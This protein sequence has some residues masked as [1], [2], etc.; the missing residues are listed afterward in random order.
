MK[1]LISKE[2]R[3]HLKKRAVLEF[4]GL[5]VLVAISYNQR[6]LIATAMTDI[7]NSDALFLFMLFGVYWLLLPLTAISYRLLSYKKIRI[8]TT[9]LSQLAAAGPGRIIPGGL[10]H[11]SIGAIHLHK[12][13]LKMQR[14][15]LIP[16]ANNIIGLIVN[17]VMVVFAV[18]YHPTL[19]DTILQSF[20]TQVLIVT[21]ILIIASVTLLQWLSHARSTRNTL[22]KINTQWK[23]LFNHLR[24]NPRRLFYVFLISATITLGHTLMLRLAGEALSVHISLYDALIALSVGVLL[25]SAVPT[26]GGLGAVEAGTTSA[27]IILGYDPAEATSTA[28]LFRTATYWQ[29]LL[30]GVLSYLY[31]RE[32]KLL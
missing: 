28:L 20:T 10:G 8:I 32:R 29:P 26:P 30:P 22:H 3:P 19:L 17:A 14:A 11:I 1:H 15:I 6:A 4:L 5:L 25:G 16:V 27:L 21:A 31:L 9:M 23:H 2:H 24:R 7:R 18:I 13:G 12:V